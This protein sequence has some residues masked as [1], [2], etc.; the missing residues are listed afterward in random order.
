MSPA[1]STRSHRLVVEVG[2]GH[3][4]RGGA[5]RRGQPSRSSVRAAARARST[6]R[7]VAPGW[8]VWFG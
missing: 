1:A 2:A 3:V 6:R 5:G 4:G 7:T 8:K